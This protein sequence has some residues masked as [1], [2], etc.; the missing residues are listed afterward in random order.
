MKFIVRAPPKLS[1][2]N[3][4]NLGGLITAVIPCGYFNRGEVILLRRTAVILTFS[5]TAPSLSGVHGPQLWYSVLRSVP[6]GEKE[7]DTSHPPPWEFTSDRIPH[8]I[9]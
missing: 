8:I 2:S 5:H 4:L 1:G 6:G 9:H 3:P 7:R